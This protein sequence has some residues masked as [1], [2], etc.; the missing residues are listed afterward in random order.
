M[1]YLLLFGT[2]ILYDI[3]VVMWYKAM[4]S[5]AIVLA[6]CYA[7]LMVLIAN[8]EARAFVFDTLALVPLCLGTFIGTF[9]GFKV[10]KYIERSVKRPT[11]S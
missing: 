10:G 9:V 3:I 7:P 5:E 1:L 6:S 8:F 11:V 4:Q 2:A